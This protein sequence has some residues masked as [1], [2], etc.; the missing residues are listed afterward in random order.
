MAIWDDAVNESKKIT[1][2]VA[3]THKCPGCGSNLVVNGKTGQLE[4]KSCGGKYY[5]EFFEISELLKKVNDEEETDF[6]DSDKMQKQE[7]VCNACGATVVTD[8]NTASTFCAFCGSPALVTNRLTKAFKPDYIIPFKLSKKDAEA[9][10]KE[11]AS[12]KKFLPKDFLSEKNLKKITGLYVPFWM[13]DADCHIDIDAGGSVETNNEI[14]FYSV[15]RSGTFRMKKVPFDG[16]KHINDRLME[17]IEPFDYSEL[18]PYSSGYLPGY[19]AE[20][21]DLSVKDMAKRISDRFRDYMFETRDAYMNVHQYTSYS[22]DYDYSSSNNYVCKYA[23]LPVWF[24]NY[25]Y[26]GLYYRIAIN[27]QT[28]EIA[29]RAPV[30]ERKKKLKRASIYAWGY[31]KYFLLL[32]F[33]LVLFNAAIKVIVSDYDT[34]ITILCL[35]P[36]LVLLLGLIMSL[37][38][39]QNKVSNQFKGLLKK[40][41]EDAFSIDEKP[42]KMPPAITYLDGSF[43][44]EIEKEDKLIHSSPKF[45]VV[46]DKRNVGLF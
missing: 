38:S 16:S 12:T 18:V 26:E 13:I 22:V 44:T 23:L 30:D 10:L 15:K 28:G 27:G 35:S 14:T 19:Y 41:E 4:C 42:Y 39:V 21:Y 11:W 43:R 8:H 5:P 33:I 36:G 1:K 17:S 24:I 3:D 29:G 45:N 34:F 40:V 2:S 31:G 46:E 9:K 25:E 32:A 6:D 7:I 20:R 37:P